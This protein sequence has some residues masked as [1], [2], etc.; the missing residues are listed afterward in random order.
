[1][2]TNYIRLDK[3]IFNIFI[4]QN[5]VYLLK[6]NAVTKLIIPFTRNLKNSTG[7]EVAHLATRPRASI[8][9]PSLALR[10]HS[11]YQLIP[12]RYN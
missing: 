7:V 12:N 3:I 4:L 9:R 11:V 8:G 5:V 2:H 1:M 10:K 6:S